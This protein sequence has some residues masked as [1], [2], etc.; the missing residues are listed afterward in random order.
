MKRTNP[1]ETYL[2]VGTFR[3]DLFYTTDPSTRLGVFERLVV[4]AVVVA[5]AAVEATTVPFPP[6]YSNHSSASS[7]LSLLGL[8]FN[9]YWGEFFSGERI[10]KN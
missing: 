5:F 2:P 6:T 10:S 3:N 7:F 4:V 9:D 1:W 8:I